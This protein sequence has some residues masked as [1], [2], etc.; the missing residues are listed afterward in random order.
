MH[1]CTIKL[2]QECKTADFLVTLL[3][4][5]EKIY[6]CLTR[7]VAVT[8]GLWIAWQSEV[9]YSLLGVVIAD[10]RVTIS[11]SYRVFIAASFVLSKVFLNPLV[12]INTRQQR[13]I[14]FRSR[15][16][17][18]RVPFQ[19]ELQLIIRRKISTEKRRKNT[20]RY[21]AFLKLFF[22]CNYTDSIWFPA[23]L[24]WRTLCFFMCCLTHSRFF[25]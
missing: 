17:A 24:S 22:R 16:L 3:E 13:N 21:P 4:S 14:T 12:K 19:K 2:F 9:L 25:F 11:C 6:S 10:T 20:P 1:V 7:L 15:L 23:V 8:Q 5:Q 18:S